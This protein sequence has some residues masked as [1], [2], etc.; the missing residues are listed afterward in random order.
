M[1]KFTGKLKV[2]LGRFL[3][4]TSKLVMLLILA[5]LAYVVALAWNDYMRYKLQS[6]EDGSR[7]GYAASVTGIAI[8]F[9]VLF[10]FFGV[11]SKFGV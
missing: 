5:S 4:N 6:S 2:G 7:L 9:G 10:S 3:T 11:N 8:V 1:S